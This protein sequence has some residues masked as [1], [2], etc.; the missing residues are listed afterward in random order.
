MGNMD[1]LELP[2]FQAVDLCN[3]H[4]EQGGPAYRRSLGQS[5]V[6]QAGPQLHRGGVAHGD[7]RPEGQ[8]QVA[9]VAGASCRRK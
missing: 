2:S 6:A 3:V 5:E 4:L 9:L 7:G 8:G 1:W